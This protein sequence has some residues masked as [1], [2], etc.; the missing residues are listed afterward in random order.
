M[1]EGPISLASTLSSVVP[2]VIPAIVTSQT[3]EGQDS[4]SSEA[5][6][7]LFTGLPLRSVLGNWSSVGQELCPVGKR[8]YPT[9]HVVLLIRA[10]TESVALAS[11]GIFHQH[12]FIVFAS[13][14][15]RSDPT[16]IRVLSAERPQSIHSLTPSLPKT[17]ICV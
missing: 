3:S 5:S 9:N 13:G 15:S 16:F 8:T 14:I 7:P 1:I 2:Y 17:I 4:C 10:Q 11:L 12:R 6:D